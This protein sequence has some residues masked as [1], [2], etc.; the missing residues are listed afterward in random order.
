[1]DPSAL[2]L[3]LYDY[4]PVTDPRLHQT[5][6]IIESE[7]CEDGLLYRRLEDESGRVEGTFNLCTLW[8]V[9]YWARAG[10]RERARKLFERFLKRGNSLNLYSEEINAATGAYLGNYP[11]L[12]VHAAIIVAADALEQPDFPAGEA[13]PHAAPHPSR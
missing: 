10:E 7:L 12:F 9:I 11:Q 13:R 3:G 2:L 6:Q 5:A 8:L 1:V 4:L